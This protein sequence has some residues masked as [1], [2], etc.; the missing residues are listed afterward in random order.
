MAKKASKKAKKKVTNKNTRTKKAARVS[1]KK[2][3]RSAVSRVSKVTKKTQGSTVE[4]INIPK[5][6]TT[7]Q[8]TPHQHHAPEHISPPKGPRM[9]KPRAWAG[10]LINILVAPGLGTLI[11]G[12]FAEGM[13]QLLIFLVAMLFLMMTGEFVLSMVLVIIA[14]IWSIFSSI[15]AF[16]QIQ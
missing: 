13:I 8:H 7:P 6:Q 4:I 12:N 11:L 15:N 10:F 16:N 14:L 3:S 9:D 5:E 1:K 2:S